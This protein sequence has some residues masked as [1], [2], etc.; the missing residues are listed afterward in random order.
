M[1]HCVIGAVDRP[2]KGGGMD[3]NSWLAINVHR[4][5]V[6]NPSP[7]ALKRGAEAGCTDWSL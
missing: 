2:L 4:G 6:G 3:C 5:L 1:V 7:I